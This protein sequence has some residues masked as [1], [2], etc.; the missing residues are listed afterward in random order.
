[1]GGTAGRVPLNLARED[2]Y[3]YV[4]KTMHK[5]IKE[6]DVRFVKWDHNVHLTYSGDLSFASDEQRTVRIRYVE[7]LYRLVS[8]LRKDFPD[9]WF[10]NCSSG[11]GRVDMEMARYFDVNWG[12]DNTDP[13]ERIFIHDSYLALFPA[14][15]L[16]SWVTPQ[17]WHL[18]NPSLAYKFDVSM[19]GVLGVGID[20]TKLTNQERELAKNKIALYKEIRET[21]HNG[22]VFR[23]LSPFETNRS[24]IQYVSKNKKSS[25]V[26][27]Y[28]LAEYPDISIP[29]N[30]QSP[31][32]K[33]RGLD[34]NAT[35]RIDKINGV[36]SGK[37][38]ME[39]GIIFP[40]K[41]SYKSD[42][43]K[44]ETIHSPS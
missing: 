18:Q 7:N 39:T 41:G 33:L 27:N 31:L 38:L 34:P 25:V 35:Y 19:I 5:V 11:A 6:S 26:F 8:A 9:V 28:H 29:E 40:L 14:N 23:I 15:T 32:V 37:Y 16:I 12:S 1:M 43:Y 44:I 30:R 10:E 2:V 24:I 20:L 17:D 13:I 22:D 3:Q 4:Y 42:I 21:I 36:Y